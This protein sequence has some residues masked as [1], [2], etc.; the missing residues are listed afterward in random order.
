MSATTAPAPGTAPRSPHALHGLSSFTHHHNLQG[1]KHCPPFS[2]EETE[3]QTSGVTSLRFQRGKTKLEFKPRPAQLS[4]KFYFLTSSLH[5][6]ASQSCSRRLTLLKSSLN[7]KLTHY[8]RHLDSRCLKKWVISEKT[9]A[10]PWGWFW[11]QDIR[12]LGAWV[13]G[14]LLAHSIASNTSLILPPYVLL[15]PLGAVVP[16]TCLSLLNVD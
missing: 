4:S 16:A 6:P 3:S 15:L 10:G 12:N 7:C 1:A 13:S 8:H 11:R 9:K 5:N 14:F 2:E